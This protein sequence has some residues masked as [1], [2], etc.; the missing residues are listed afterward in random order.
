[1]KRQA[2]A[3]HKVDITDEYE[4]LAFDRERVV[5]AARRVLERA[6]VTTAAISVA[7]VDNATIHA[8]NVEF[9]QHDFPT[10]VITFPLEQSDERL[11]GELV[12]SGEY[13]E[14]MAAEFGWS[15]ADELLLYVV[16]GA[17]HLVGYD[18]LDETSLTTMRQQ[19]DE[20]L[21]HFGL[22]VPRVSR[23]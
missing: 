12:V 18:D 7:V 21:S 2:R 16:H 15:A 19:E 1:M 6:R 3:R 4:R 8:L 9:L 22:R 23:R 14:T 11:E 20:V 13:A 17:L 5:A 10:D